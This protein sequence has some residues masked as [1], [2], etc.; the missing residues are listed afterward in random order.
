MFSLLP[1]V[2]AASARQ[3]QRWMRPL[4][5]AAGLYN[6]LWGAAVIL[7]PGP[8]AWLAG[9]DPERLAYP[10]L[11]QCIGMIVGVYG[12]GYWVAAEDAYRHWPVVLVGFLGKT[13][14]PIGAVQNI[15][16]GQLP[17][18]IL[19]T[20]LTNDLIWWL[21]F[22]LILLGAARAAQ[23]RRQSERPGGEDATPT[24]EAAVAQGRTLAVFLRHAG[25]TFC[26]EAVA[27]LNA[28]AS[29]LRERGVGL[30]LVTPGP[31]D[32]DTLLAGAPNLRDVPIIEDRT[33]A[34]AARH[35]FKQGG[36]AELFG[37]AV[38]GP[39]ARACLIDRHGVGKLAGNG[40]QMPGLALYDG[41][42]WTRHHTHRTAA[43]RPDYLS[44]VDAA[45]PA[46]TE[47]TTQ[48]ATAAGPVG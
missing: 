6:V 1:A 10:Q 2:D 24:F 13:L 15:V 20:N 16:T 27:D 12:V 31:A 38:W 43:E 9:F 33:G 7:L 39:G 37:P 22:G 14:G 26:R 41:G 44:F 47:V 32:R 25:C 29:S 8:T 19:W 46:G 48:A 23:V 28:A 17:A 30:L 3:P 42:R 4:L 45:G 5:K 34:I 18:R 40:F 36:A 21:P 35:D 11:W